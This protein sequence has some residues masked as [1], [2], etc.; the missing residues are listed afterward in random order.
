MATLEGVVRKASKMSRPELGRRGGLPGP[1]PVLQFAFATQDRHPLGR[2]D[3]EQRPGVGTELEPRV[4]TA[5]RKARSSG[6]DRS[7]AKWSSAWS[8]SSTSTAVCAASAGYFGIAVL[9]DL[10]AEAGVLEGVRAERLLDERLGGEKRRA[11]GPRP[12]G[13]PVRVV[14]DRLVLVA[15]VP[16][17]VAGA[18]AAIRVQIAAG[19][20][21][22]VDPRDSRPDRA[23]L[24]QDV[25]AVAVRGC[26]GPD[27]VSGSRGSFTWASSLRGSPIIKVRDR[28]ETAVLRSDKLD[29][30]GN[31]LPSE[32][33]RYGG[34]L[35]PDTD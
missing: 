33:S 3:D 21:A 8:Q 22:A 29:R 23:R 18:G 11:A 4:A 5:P 15:D 20:L 30:R 25:D 13:D 28:N 1:V 32:A 10:G 27:L 31:R 35:R 9:H 26:V 6:G 2:R 14:D 16:G 34:F 17:Q 12:A 7:T 19:E 24:A